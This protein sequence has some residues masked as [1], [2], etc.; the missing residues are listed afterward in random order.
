MMLIARMEIELS[1]NGIGCLADIL[2]TQNKERVI[3]PVVMYHEFKD[4]TAYE[5]IPESNKA[6]KRFIEMCEREYKHHLISERDKEITKDFIKHYPK[7]WDECV[8]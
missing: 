4:V 7:R 1:S 8:L 6:I 3:V 5:I 2:I